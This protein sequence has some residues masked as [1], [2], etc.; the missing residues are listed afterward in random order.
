MGAGGQDAAEEAAVDGDLCRRAEMS[1][2]A[3]GLVE[4]ALA[5]LGV[6]EGYGDEVVPKLA[7]EMGPGGV[8]E[9]AG[10]EGFEPEGAVVFIFVDEVEHAVAENDDG[11]SVAEMKFVI[12]AVGAF[13]SGGDG[14]FEGKSATFAERRFDVIDVVAAGIADIAFVGSGARVAAELAGFRIDEREDG[15]EPACDRWGKR[16]KQWHNPNANETFVGAKR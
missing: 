10:E 12:A 7:V 5:E 16:R 13:E 4:F 15:I 9:Q 8:D 1:G 11:A 3:F 2:Q 6:V 14:A